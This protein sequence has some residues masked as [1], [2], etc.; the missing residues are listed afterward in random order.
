MILGK[1]PINPRSDAAKPSS[2]PA[3]S[4]TPAA[5]TGSLPGAAPAGR[6]QAKVRYVERPD[7]LEQFADS[8]TGLYFDGQTMRIEFSVTRVDEVKPNEPV[9]A[10]RYPVCRVVVPR[11][12]AIELINRL[13]QIASALAQAGVIKPTPQSTE[14]PKAG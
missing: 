7:V 1:D 13:Q 10:R 11:T 9:T 4:A 5:V 6:Q 14:V 12:A 2:N 3:A 8:I